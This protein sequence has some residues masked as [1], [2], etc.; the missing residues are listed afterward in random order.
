[1]SRLL[2][3]LEF[4]NVFVWQTWP[5]NY[6]SQ[7]P[8]RDYWLQLLLSTLAV[9]AAL[10]LVFEGML[11]VIGVPLIE[12]DSV[13]N[14]SPEMVADLYEQLA[15]G[16]LATVSCPCTQTSTSLASVSNW[17]APEDSFCNALREIQQI[18]P[19][20][21]NA[22][23]F[24][25]SLLSDVANEACIGIPGPLGTDPGWDAFLTSV[26]AAAVT[27]A[28]FPPDPPADLADDIFALAVDLQR[29]L[30]GAAF[31][32]VSTGFPVF[33]NSPLLPTFTTSLDNACSEP[34]NT[35]VP[36]FVR[37]Q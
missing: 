23:E 13:A 11:Q 35:E 32:S 7:V 28:L 8:R 5:R 14:P 34:V 3:P 4:T 22:L 25:G 27:G 2:L 33:V 36:F 17:S 31:G 37:T 19:A 10:F 26:T 20:N 24:L 15:A 12:A 21:L 6:K 16:E 9:T 18:P 30:C 1:M 29:A